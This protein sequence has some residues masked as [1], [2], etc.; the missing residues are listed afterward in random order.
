MRSVFKFFKKPGDAAID[1]EFRSIYQRKCGRFLA[2]AFFFAGVIF[3]GFYILDSVNGILPS[4]GGI[5]TFRL[6]V[7]ATLFCA[8]VAAFVKDAFVVKHF[9]IIG[10]ISCLLA[11]EAVAYTAFKSRQDLSFTELYWGLTSSLCTSALVIYGFVRLPARNTAIVVGIGSVSGIIYALQIPEHHAQ[12][13]RLIAHLGIVNVVAFYMGSTIET[14]ERELFLLGKENLRNN[15]Y[16]KELEAAKIAAEEGDAA[17]SRFLAN[18]SHEVRTP[19]NGVLMIMDLIGKNASAADRALIEQ[20]RASGNALLKIIETV[21]NFT[22]LSQGKAD[23]SPAT[24][25]LMDT[26]ATVVSLHAAAAAAAKIELKSKVELPSNDRLVVIDEVKLYE[27]MSNLVSNAVK[28]TESGFVELTVKVQRALTDEMKGTLSISVKDTGIGLSTE[29]QRKI[30]TAF[31]QAESGTTRKAGG[32]GLGLSI[33][34]E[35][36]SVLGGTVE[37]ASALTV[38]STFA[39]ELPVGLVTGTA[40]KASTVAYIGARDIPASPTPCKVIAFPSSS[41][42][43]SSNGRALLVEDNE[44]NYVLESR[45][46][47][48]IGFQ[49]VVAKNGLE[50]F[51]EFRRNQYDIVFMDCMM[52]VMDG[53]ESTKRMRQYELENGVHRPTPII[54]ITAD[55][56]DGAR[57][58]CI[59][60]GM[61]D[62]MT[63]PCDEAAMR[64]MTIRWLGRRQQPEV[65]G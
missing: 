5:Q 46:L 49:V 59:N 47:E 15:I 26:C 17:K 52:P 51:D 30:F 38:G 61:T 16:A 32:T 18:M 35:L 22:K 28:F 14:R 12:L 21:L 43:S 65:A 54:A 63:K 24:V 45:L 40:A 48:L 25:N 50:G 8:S 41:P 33:V 11:L 9:A 60:A 39:V 23:V 44:L 10:N 53:Y 27:I 62:Y 13:G 31:Y 56:L 3:G 55:T 4:F 6:C 36:V 7:T 19:M 64:A 2:V 29:D 57:E 1:A 42:V 58:R 34:K 20:G 37:V